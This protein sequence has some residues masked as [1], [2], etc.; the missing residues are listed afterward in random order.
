MRLQKSLEQFGYNTNEVKTYLASLSLGE[1]TVTEIAAKARIPR[2][3]CQHSITALQQEGLMY[4]LVKRRRKY[5]VAESPQKIL[6]KL[7]E[8]EKTLKVILP[9]LQALRYET[10][11][12]RP[13]IQFFRGKE[14][15]SHVLDD[16]IE[17]KH[18]ILSLTPVKDTL[19]LLDDDFQEFIERRYAHYLQV[20]LLTQK[21]TET[22][23]LKKR[24]AQELRQTRFLPDDFDIKNANFIYGDKVAIISL[25]KK[26]PTGI[27][28]EDKDIADTQRTLFQFMWDQSSE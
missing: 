4:S 24:D 7:H 2:T 5:W 26:L 13:T 18:H 15:V 28:M 1:T 6:L 21:S 14:G 19:I 12:R 27:I 16:I 8:K 17:T 23:A 11:I 22:V 25:N 10:G 9:E 3:T 20:Q